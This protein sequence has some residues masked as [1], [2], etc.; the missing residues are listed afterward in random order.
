MFC[1]HC[2]FPAM[3]TETDTFGSRLRRAREI[4]GLSQDQMAARI[5]VSLRSYSRYENEGRELPIGA[6]MRAAEMGISVT[7]LLTG[8][9]EPLADAKAAG[10][11]EIS[12]KLDAIEDELR[13]SQVPIG[14]NKLV[15]GSRLKELHS[16]LIELAGNAS[17]A[18]DRARAN[19]MLNVAF[20]NSEAAAHREAHV[21]MS[22]FRQRMLVATDA[23]A[24]VLR[25]LDW[26][27]PAMTGMAVRDAM[28]V[29]GLSEEMARFILAALREDLLKT[30]TA[31]GKQ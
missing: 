30:E 20:A 22:S 9:G 14:T 8:A 21:D 18:G 2:D 31:G 10:I 27:P 1:N 26:E 5:G 23:Y 16:Q 24:R 3:M 17:A 19:M 25:E 7:W 15:E 11:G 6:L 28:I 4:I 13:R 12:R 29:D